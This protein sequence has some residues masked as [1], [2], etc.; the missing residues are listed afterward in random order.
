MQSDRRA[1][2]IPRFLNQ[3][4]VPPRPAFRALAAIVAGA[5]AACGFQPLALWPLTLIGVA[6]LLEL[7]SRARTG[8]QVFAL[9]WCFGLGHF[10][11]GNNWIATAFTYQANI[12][13]WLGMI[14]VALIAVYL[15]LF[16]ALAAL[17]AWLV[18]RPQGRGR[19]A[20]FLLAFAAAW[21]VTEWTRSWL[22]S[23]FAWNPLGVALLGPFDSR[24]LALITPWI[25]TYGL[26]GVLALLAGLPGLCVRAADGHDRIGRLLWGLPV[27]AFAGALALVMIMPGPPAREG[28]VPYTLVQPDLRQEVIDDP[29]EFEPSF[30][31]L[32]MLSLPRGTGDRRVVF[33]PESGLADFLRDGYPAYVY[34]AYNY[35]GDPALSRMRIGRV[36]GPYGLLLTGAVDV[37]IEHGEDVAARNSVTALDGDGDILAGYSK[38]HLV[39]FGE[40]LPLR[41]I[42]EP[43]GASRF[44]AGQLDFWPGPGPRTIDFGVYGEAGI[45]ICYEI[46]F[47]G[48]VVDPANRPDYIFNPS[49]DGWFGAWG[50]PQHLAQARLRAIEEGLPVLRST[51][52]GISAVVD[53]DGI[54]RAFVPRHQA[55]RLDGMIPLAHEPTLFAR[56]GNV[57]PLGF[58]AMLF[59]ASL[60]VVALKRRQG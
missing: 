45:Q 20:S 14:A 3:T 29:R 52:T 43:L 21:I 53:A 23:G 16:P 40:Y 56:Y 19:F 35:G 30:R 4:L 49:N 18:A 8:R 28:A 12:P 11:L 22:F 39:P 33:W 25:G 26:S 1:S 31:K 32:A 27:L 58:A 37:V 57:L 48:Q 51:T 9:G 46:I 50:P 59:F 10:T 13:A 55:G 38:A 7:I 34:S 6:W 60:C 2:P 44:V 5:A 17:G 36:I 42:L 24:G 41:W 47:S 15:A 54:V